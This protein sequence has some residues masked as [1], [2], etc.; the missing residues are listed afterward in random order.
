[1]HEYPVRLVSLISV[2]QNH[3]HHPFELSESDT[4]KK[5]TML[6]VVVVVI[7]VECLSFE[8]VG[9]NNTATFTIFL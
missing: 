9:R 1:M 6:V 2:Y 8:L 7:V 5:A 3:R 4:R